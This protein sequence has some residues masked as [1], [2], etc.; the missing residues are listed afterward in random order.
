MKR[1]K[2]KAYPNSIC[3]VIYQRGQYAT[4]AKLDSVNPSTRALE[5]ANDLLAVGCKELPDNLVF[6]AMFP[7]GRE[8]YKKI[9]GEYFCL[10]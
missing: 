9:D 2:S 10:A 7:Q 3:G 1:V 5:I 6:Q 8:V 4:A